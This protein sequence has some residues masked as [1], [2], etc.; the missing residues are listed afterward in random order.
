MLSSLVVLEHSDPQVGETTAA[1]VVG[2]G[3]SESREGVATSP[4]LPLFQLARW[5]NR[6]QNVLVCRCVAREE[7]TVTV[8]PPV[9]QV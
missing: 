3:Q 8:T 9:P 1:D 5:E 7:S 6:K 2:R 4:S